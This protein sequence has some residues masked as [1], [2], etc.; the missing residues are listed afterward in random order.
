M[1]DNAVLLV[2]AEIYAKSK[3]LVLIRQ[4]MLGHGSDG[5][6][7]RTSRDTALKVLHK[8]ENFTNEL[9][10][11]RRFKAAGVRSIGRFAVPF[12]EGSDE[13][14]RVIEMTIVDPPFLLDFGKVHLDVPPPYFGDKQ[15]MA[16]AYSEWRER[17]GSDW[18]A[19]ASVLGVLRA[20]FGIYYVDPRPSN[21]C[22]RHDD[23]PDGEPIGDSPESFP[24]EDD[25]AT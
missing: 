2:S 14:L 1:I 25:D 18:L 22:L 11:Y 15:L 5:A 20:K 8:E 6:V 24:D 13:S 7:W 21:I 10:C 4:P 16:N 3:G 12:L 19:I 9:E 23:G 17:Y